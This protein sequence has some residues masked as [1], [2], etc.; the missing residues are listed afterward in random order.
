MFSFRGVTANQK[1]KNC[2]HLLYVY[3]YVLLMH[4]HTT[5]VYRGHINT[6]NVYCNNENNEK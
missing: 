3:T 5:N 2:K 1:K 6:A 4:L